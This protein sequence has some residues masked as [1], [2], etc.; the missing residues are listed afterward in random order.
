MDITVCVGDLVSVTVEDDTAPN[1]DALESVLR[2]AG[3]EAL[4][5]HAALAASARDE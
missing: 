1:L 5:V 3:D 4:R 2:R